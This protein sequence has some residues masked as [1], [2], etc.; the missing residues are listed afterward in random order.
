MTVFTCEDSFEAMLTAIYD[1]FMSRLGHANV[2]LMV[3]P[4]EQYSMFETYVH[5]EPSTAKAEEVVRSIMCKISPG[6]YDATASILGAYEKDTLNTVYR[7]LALGFKY[8]PRVLDMYQF[9]DVARFNAI[10]IRYAREANSFLE[11]LRFS[12]IDDVY[13]AH[14]EPKSNV[15][16]SVAGHF[17]DRMPSEHWMIID[18]IRHEAV[19]HPKNE[20]FFLRK[21]SLEEYTRLKE[22]DVQ[23]DCFSAMW[24]GYF[25]HISIKERENYRCQLGHFPKWKRKHVTEFSK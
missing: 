5:V 16:L 1:A 19:I 4:I 8:G 12:S 2:R 17:L 24:Q 11:F 9:P 6:F 20:G 22:T 15:L 18:D 13:I 3:E 23:R 14:L 7:V 10:S 25:E 21:L